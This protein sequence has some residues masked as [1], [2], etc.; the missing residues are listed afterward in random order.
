MV[1][2]LTNN[3]TL[4]KMWFLVSDTKPWW[5]RLFFGWRGTFGDSAEFVF[6]KRDWALI[7]ENA[8]DSKEGN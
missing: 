1:K 5:F 4:K 6:S 2:I 8:K 7:Q 3:E